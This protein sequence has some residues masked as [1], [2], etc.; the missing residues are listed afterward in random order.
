MWCSNRVQQSNQ[1]C[2]Q[3]IASRGRIFT[4]EELTVTREINREFIQ[5]LRRLP[6]VD[7][8]RQLTEV[9]VGDR[10]NHRDFF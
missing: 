7:E 2:C 8:R 1:R 5:Q 6:S 3:D 4:G 9:L 10:M